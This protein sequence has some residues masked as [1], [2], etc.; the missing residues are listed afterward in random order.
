MHEQ[1]AVAVPPNNLMAEQSVLGGLLIDNSAW[2]KVQGL[3][4]HQDFYTRP[5]QILFKAIAVMLS[6]GDAVDILTIMDFL[7]AKGHHETV[8]GLGYVGQIAAD[9]PSVANIVAYAQIVRDKSVA[10]QMIQLSRE[11]AEKAFSGDTDGRGLLQFAESGV[12]AMGQKLL[13]GK[14]GFIRSRDMM[15]DVIERI[16]QNYD[17][18]ASGVLG[19]SSG[20]QSLDAVTSGFM[21]GDLVVIAAR[22]AMGKTAFAMNLAAA[23]A[24]SG[25]VVAVFSMEMQAYQLGQ[26][27][28][29][30][31]SGVGLKR[32]RE[33]WHLYD[34]DWP[35]LTAGMSRV[36]DV[37]LFVDDSPGL[38]VSDIRSRAM[39]LSSEVR[40]ECA[41]GVG[42]IVIDYLQLMGNDNVKAGNRN[43]EIGEITRALK[44]MAKDFNIP[45]LLLS[46]LNRDLERRPNKRPLPSDLRDS[47][48]IEQDADLI[49]FLYRDEVY[50]PDSVDTGIAE[51][52]LGKQRMGALATVRLGFDADCV[53]FRELGNE[54]H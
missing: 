50:N 41:A 40:D 13:R 43:D 38:S 47:G 35:C 11:L 46:Q 7:E 3:L 8:G 1:S 19:V 42:L 22:P 26:R 15:R 49:V 36:A 23:S 10:R 37:P 53:R 44:V 29:S 28:L 33:S 45:I 2:P 48:S 31:A 27:L 21:G 18:P 4:Q 17:K 24:E 5:N 16:E 52:I 25:R 34:T 39:M 12:F 51:V 6:R 14:R 30:A 9:T 54:V 32:I 20:Y